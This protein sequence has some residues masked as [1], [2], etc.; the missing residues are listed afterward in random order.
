MS[1]TGH[2]DDAPESPLTPTNIGPDPGSPPEESVREQMSEV[3]NALREIRS[4]LADQNKYLEGLAAKPIK[5]TSQR[6]RAVYIDYKEWTDKIL[7]FQEKW[8]RSRIPNEEL[9]LILKRDFFWLFE[10]LHQAHWDK[11]TISAPSD[12]DHAGDSLNTGSIETL[13]SAWPVYEDPSQDIDLA[14]A[15]ALE[16]SPFDFDCFFPNCAGARR[17]NMDG[18]L[19]QVLWPD[20][21]IHMYKICFKI[22]PSPGL[23][24]GSFSS[25]R[26]LTQEATIIG[27]PQPPAEPWGGRVCGRIILQGSSISLHARAMIPVR[28]LAFILWQLESYSAGKPGYRRDMDWDVDS[29]GR[30]CI[31]MF[32]S[33]WG[34]LPIFN[35][36]NGVSDGLLSLYFQIRWMTVSPQRRSLPKK[37]DGIL[38]NRDAGDIPNGPDGSPRDHQVCEERYVFGLVTTISQKIALYTLLSVTDGESPL[39]GQTLEEYL[40]LGLQ[41]TAQR[42]LSGRLMGVGMYLLYISATL[43]W[44]AGQ[45]ELTLDQLDNTLHTSLA[46]MTRE[47]R[48]SLMFDDDF[49]KSDQYFAALQTLHMCTDWIKGTLR[50]F[51]D[52]CENTKRK[53]SRSLEITDGDDDMDSFEALCVDVLANSERHFQPLLDRI[54]RKVEEVKGLRDGLFNA[55]SVK[56]ASK[57][58]KLAENSRRQNRYILVFTVATVFYLPMGFVTSFFGMHL[59]DPNDESSASRTPFIITFVVIAIATYVIATGALLVIRE[60]DWIKSTLRAWKA[61]MWSQ[62]TQAQNLA[63][64]RL[65]GLLGRRK[66]RREADV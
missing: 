39:F 47:K 5:A 54:E 19:R 64:S 30:L 9:C 65:S 55:T 37:A 56:E 59:F 57:G 42:Y 25:A 52:L 61:S 10:D 23:G 1:S 51:R 17:L 12:S 53:I 11:L 26:A 35:A 6:S 4:Q 29:A 21:S 18:A 63:G 45:W 3:V 20:H 7:P 60:D 28:T 40:G 22:G 66:S 15:Y 16:D 50:D 13:K 24:S 38:L 43:E 34:R 46:Q 36:F 49:S 41:N 2:A 31:L 58:T 33:H 14:A 8:H 27:C 48:R 44:T 62:D 32:A